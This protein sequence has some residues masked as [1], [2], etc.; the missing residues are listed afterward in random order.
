MKVY[1]KVKILIVSILSNSEAISCNLSQASHPV[2]EMSLQAIMRPNDQ[3]FVDNLTEKKC[4][5]L[6]K[7]IYNSVASHTSVLGKKKK[8]QAVLSF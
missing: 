1:S 8:L 6:D 2:L 7:R 5:L 3:T 4:S